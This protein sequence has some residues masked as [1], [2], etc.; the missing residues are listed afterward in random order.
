[1]LRW[2]L[3]ASIAALL[4]IS[5]CAQLATTTALVGNVTD[6]SGQ[7]VPGAKVTAVNRDTADTYNSMTNDQ[8]YYNIQF[9]RVGTYNLTFE[10]AGFQK[11]EKVGVVVENNQIV[12]TDV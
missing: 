9:V 2:F 1:M 4:M 3:A 12:R 8:G 6:T 10:K 7:T 11:V 5:A